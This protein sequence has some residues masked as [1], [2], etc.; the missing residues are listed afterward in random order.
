MVVI[1]S[2]LAMRCERESLGRAI[3]TVG[4]RSGFN[5]RAG[6]EAAFKE[7]ARSIDPST[8]A[9][10]TEQREADARFR[11]YFD[12]AAADALFVH[13]EAGNIRDVN[14][15]AC[16]RVGCAWRTVCSIC[17]V[18]TKG[19][20][21]GREELIGKS[22]PRSIRMSNEELPKC[23]ECER[24]ARAAETQMIQEQCGEGLARRGAEQLRR[25]VVRGHPHSRSLRLPC[26]G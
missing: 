25:L 21:A 4:I 18:P 1:P 12:D 17:A 7:A 13:D 10:K 16:D 5:Q 22:L 26:G 14:R 23:A 8:S 20:A 3:P 15:E 19:R 11:A 9:V 2:R 6:F 24:G